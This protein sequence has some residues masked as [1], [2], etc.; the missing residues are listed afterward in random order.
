MEIFAEI[1]NNF[2]GLI[3]SIGV[4]FYLLKQIENA[5]PESKLYLIS[6][7]ESVIIIFQFITSNMIVNFRF[8]NIIDRIF[9]MAM[10]GIMIINAHTDSN[11]KIIYRPFNYCI[12]IIG[13]IYMI[14]K[15]FILKQYPFI[16]ESPLN[17]LL[18]TGIFIAIIYVFTFVLHL[19]G[20]G[21]GYM[22]IGITLFTP[23]MADNTIFI[24][25]IIM[26]LLYI[27]SGLIQIFS[28]LD[29]LEIKKLRFKEKLPFAP[30]Y[31]YGIWL[32][33]LLTNFFSTDIF[34]LWWI[35]NM[36]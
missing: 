22:V 20:K 7:N 23:F 8:D 35:E 34:K 5:D 33:L 30:A 6:K 36:L 28:N 27:A 19:S 14:L 29:K 18:Y 15:L 2:T 1:F 21:D 16:D 11:Q 32:I 17:T 31:L 10:L 9:Y 24:S 12:W 13:A 26:F 4:F 3:I 25:L